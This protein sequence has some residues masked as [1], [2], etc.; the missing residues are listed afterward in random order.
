MDDEKVKSLIKLSPMEET[1]MS[2]LSIPVEQI[3][4]VF[5]CEGIS[6]K[7]IAVRFFLSE[8]QIQKIITDNKLEELRSAYLRQGISELQNVQINQAQKLMNL[9]TKFK[10]MRIIQLEKILE[11]HIAYHQRHGHFYKLH[12]V[13]GEILRDTNGLPIQLKLPNI[14][15]EITDLKETVSLSEGLKQL[16][17][18]LDD[19]INK[20]KDAERIDSETIDMAKFGNLFEA[21]LP[22]DP[23]GDDE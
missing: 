22:E 15:K 2:H 23:E 4:S 3:K 18:K 8:G 19:I 6:A 17:S 1:G 16:L 21:R 7:E 11:D 9:E 10:S 14:T 20:P 13:T 5:I 12:P